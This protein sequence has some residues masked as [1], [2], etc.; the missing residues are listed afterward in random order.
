MVD[1][2]HLNI[3]KY[4][5]SIGMWTTI[6]NIDRYSNHRISSKIYGQIEYV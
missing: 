3:E 6:M 2:G 4:A 1:T 5:R